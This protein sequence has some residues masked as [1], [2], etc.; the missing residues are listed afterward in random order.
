MPECYI[1]RQPIFDRRNRVCAY[2]L[3]YRSSLENEIGNVNRAVATS[4]VIVDAFVEIGI[5]KIVGEHRVIFNV[6]EAFLVDPD[7]LTL[8]VDRVV[9]QLPSTSS[10]TAETVAVLDRLKSDGYQIALNDYRGDL[11]VAELIDFADIVKIDALSI[12]DDT[13]ARQLATTENRELVRIAKRVE[14]TE[15][16]NVLASLG[17]DY[18]QGHFLAKPEI[19]TGQRLPSNRMAVLELVTKVCDPDVDGEELANLIAMDASLSLRI[20]RFVNSPLSGLSNEVESIHQAAVLLGRDI[21]KSWVILLAIASMDNSVPALITTAFVRAKMCEALAV[22]SNLGS[23][24]SFFTVGLFSLMDSM[25]AAPMDELLTT[26]PFSVEMKAAL[27]E[28]AGTRGEAV[29]CVQQLEIGAREWSGFGDVPGDRISELYIDSIA[30]ADQ[31]TAG[32]K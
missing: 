17:F 4:R 8:P 20:L 32:M 19:I 31:A 1:G 15:R 26:L 5:E 30:W 9:L 27:T 10:G 6:D 25:M 3:L 29:R 11:P 28:Q 24:E 22:E 16:R 23:K 7:L 13:I 21:I 14:T 12:N 2:D 18:F